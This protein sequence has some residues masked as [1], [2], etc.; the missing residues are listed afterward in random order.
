MALKRR[1]FTREFKLQVVR[2]VDAGKPSHGT[3]RLTRTLSPSGASSFGNIHRRLLP[4]MAVRTRMRRVS[5]NSNAWLVAS[6]WKT[7]C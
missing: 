3:T 2:E 5:P 4:A 1:Q 7:T 6:P